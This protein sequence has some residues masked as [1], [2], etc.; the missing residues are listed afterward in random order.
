M[1]SDKRL[2]TDIYRIGMSPS[3]IPVYTWKYKE[4]V[5]DLDQSVD[6]EGTYFGAMAQ[7]LLELAPNVVMKNPSDGYYRVDYSKIDVDS[8][9]LF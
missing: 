2:K 1:I 7:D 3:G 8:Y 4:E 9:K 5:G 6:T